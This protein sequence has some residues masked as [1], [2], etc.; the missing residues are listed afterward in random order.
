M[1]STIV[2]PP[3]PRPRAVS[4]GAGGALL[5]GVMWILSGLLAFVFQVRNMGPEGSLSWY[6]IETSDGVA[7]AGTLVALA[8]LHVKQAPRHGRLGTAGF[9]ISAAGAVSGIGA[10][11]LYVPR[12]TDGLV[13]DVLESGWLLG[14][15]VG[16]PL[17]GLATLRARL[18]PRWCGALVAGYPAVFTLAFLL[19]DQFGEIRALVGLPLLGLAY[20]LRRDGTPPGDRDLPK[21][22]GVPVQSRTATSRPAAGTRLQD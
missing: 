15:Y 4:W 18:V 8:G 17:L 3:A 16:L 22:P 20:A 10:Y 13:L 19:V 9:A 1:S 7:V 5:A 12:I 21:T 14:W 2:P 6:L 11:L